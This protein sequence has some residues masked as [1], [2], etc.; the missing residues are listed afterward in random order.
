MRRLS[1][2]VLPQDEGRQVQAL[3]RERLHMGRQ[4]IR[5][6]KFRE[7]GI[8]LDGKQARTI[9]RVHAGQTLNIA[10]GDTTDALARSLVVPTPGKLDIVFEDED[11]IVLNKPAGIATHPGPKHPT[12]TLGN[13]LMYYY[14]STNQ[15]C[16]LH[17]VHRLDWGT[18]GLMVFAKNAHAQDFLQKRLH[19]GA[20]C[21]QYVAF[22]E[23]VFAQNAGEVNVPIGCVDHVWMPLDVAKGGKPARTHYWVEA[24]GKV[25]REAPARGGEACEAPAPGAVMDEVPGAAPAPSATLAPSALPGAAPAP[26]ATLAPSAL[27]VPPRSITRVRLQLETGR[28]HQIRIHMNYLG[29]PLLGDAT[30]GGSTTMLARPALHSEFLRIEHPVTEETMEFHAPLPSDLAFLNALIEFWPSP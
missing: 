17:P 16:L 1:Y 24:G 15:H 13:I 18:S 30:H 10:V 7:E 26:S 21:R 25:S 4:G 20:F 29:H 28:T 14:Q 12:D 9:D 5:A 23:G 6:A 22:C 2:T 8:L 27:P 11:V 3:L 19:T